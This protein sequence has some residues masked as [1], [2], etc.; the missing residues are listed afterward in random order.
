MSNVWQIK[1]EIDLIV[2]PL[3]LTI[4]FYLPEYYAKSSTVMLE[5]L[6][7]DCNKS[8][9]MIQVFDFE[10]F[11]KILFRS[12]THESHFLQDNIAIFVT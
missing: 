5:I 7:K 8:L 10:V 3:T 1:L 4:D 9:F 11:F 2:N 6:S 12:C